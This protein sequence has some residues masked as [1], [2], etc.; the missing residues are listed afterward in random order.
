MFYTAGKSSTFGQISYGLSNIY[1]FK[2]ID[3]VEILLSSCD[4]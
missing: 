3:I 2:T 4:D 1:T